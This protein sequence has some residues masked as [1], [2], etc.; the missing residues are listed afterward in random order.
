MQED[1]HVTDPDIE[2]HGHLGVV[3]P[4]LHL[5]TGAVAGLAGALR[6]LGTRAALRQRGEQA[7]WRAT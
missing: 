5:R 7:G 3:G 1:D 4:G 6:G 2:F